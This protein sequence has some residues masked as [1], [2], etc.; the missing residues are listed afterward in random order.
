M[1]KQ[2]KVKKCCEGCGR[3]VLCD[4]KDIFP[5]CDDCDNVSMKSS[6]ERKKGGN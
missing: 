1:K 5:L 6:F 2:N 3:E 4:E